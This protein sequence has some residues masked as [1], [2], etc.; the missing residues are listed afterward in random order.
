MSRLIITTDNNDRIKKPQLAN[1]YY[2]K[3]NRQVSDDT[4]RD[5]GIQIKYKYNKDGKSGNAHGLFVC[6]KTIPATNP[7]IIIDIL[8]NKNPLKILQ[9]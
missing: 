8:Q 2:H 9:L 7:N 4:A 3:Y 5:E 6:V 1:L